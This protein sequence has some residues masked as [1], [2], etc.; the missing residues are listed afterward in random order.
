M[1][2][3]V[4]VSVV[5]VH[6]KCNM[7]SP[8]TPARNVL[9]STNVLVHL[10]FDQD[11]AEPLVEV[12]PAT[13]EV[14]AGRDGFVIVKAAELVVVCAPVGVVDASW[15]E[16]VIPGSNEEKFAGGSVDYITPRQPPQSPPTA[17]RREEEGRQL[18]APGL[19]YEQ[20]LHP[21]ILLSAAD[22]ALQLTLPSYWHSE[23]R[24]YTGSAHTQLKYSAV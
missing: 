13:V 1:R 14:T 23:N 5:F 15:L 18:T 9:P 4:R 12:G 10:P 16:S 11:A 3:V 19:K 17:D 7:V 2:A 22:V 8:T 24:L 6:I 20:K 21:K